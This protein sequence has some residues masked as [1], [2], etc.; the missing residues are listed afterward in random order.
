MWVRSLTKLYLN[1]YVGVIHIIKEVPSSSG[2][3]KHMCK[4]KRKHSIL[5]YIPEVCTF[6]CI[7]I[8]K[9]KISCMQHAS[10]AKQQNM[11]IYVM[12]YVCT[13]YTFM[14][15]IFI[16]KRHKKW[17]PTILRT[18]SCQISTSAVREYNWQ[19][20]PFGLGVRDH[21]G[22]WGLIYKRLKLLPALCKHI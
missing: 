21:T 7:S 10:Q 14:S 11:Y 22:K 6:V 19:A 1:I 16:T 13:R 4:S 5:M 20:N 3:C 12:I 8:Y 17:A 9:S 18:M 15:C 2:G